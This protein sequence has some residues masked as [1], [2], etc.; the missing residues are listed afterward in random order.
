LSDFIKKISFIDGDEAS[1]KLDATSVDPAS[2]KTATISDVLRRSDDPLTPKVRPNTRADS[3]PP[4]RSLLNG[5]PEPSSSRGLLWAGIILGVLTLIALATW[6][7]SHFAGANGGLDNLSTWQWAGLICA[8]IVPAAAVVALFATLNALKTVRERSDRLAAITDRLTRADSTVANEI[9]SLATVIRREIAAVDARMAETRQTLDGFK[10]AIAEQG[11]DLDKTTK[12]MAERSET[13]GRALTLHRQ[14]FDSLSTTFDAQMGRL[15]EQMSVQR[16]D[17]EGTTAKAE[18][19]LTASK[20]AIEAA[21]TALSDTISQ[22]TNSTKTAQETLDAARDRLAEIIIQVEGTTTELDTVYT[23]HSA[24][25]SALSE[26][27]IDEKNSTEAA[28]L[29]Q[30][31]RLGAID[32]QIEITE[33]RLSQLVDHARSIHE[34][35]STQITAIDNTLDSADARS[36]R[37]TADLSNRVSDAVADAR[38]DIS[39]MEED[40]RALQV[41]L[42]T[43]DDASAELDL[44][45]GP[46]QS[47]SSRVR[48]RPLETDFPSLEPPHPTYNEREK[49]PLDL[50]ELAKDDSQPSTDDISLEA[51]TPLGESRGG[52]RDVLRRPGDPEPSKKR[53]SFGRANEESK[54]ERSGWRWRDML[55]GMDPLDSEA[56]GSKNIIDNN[57]KIIRPPAG[58]PLSPIPPAPQLP[59]GSDVVA[60]LCEVQL[61]PSAVV[62]EGTIIEASQ[63]QTTV[64]KEQMAKLVSHRLD[65]P[66][67]HLRG[68]LAADLEFK[69]RA[70][71]FV[72]SMDGQ[73][74]SIS[75]PDKMRAT[76]GSASGRAFLLCSAALQS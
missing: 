50:V 4:I 22:A 29:A 51:D 32:A 35:L 62:D 48:L 75:D 17:F 23:K 46:S 61:A 1:G 37:F 64:G 14:A 72:R 67:A 44:T 11:K 30:A 33:S 38:R 52:N 63:T 16:T 69:L 3:A 68:V 47:P 58:V 18:A 49:T 15:S 41:R 5:E 28:L 55:G 60:R 76:L 26:K 42:R 73:V 19:D 25:L 45:A 65:G 36:Q 57:P 59:D 20:T 34:T 71:S 13:V 66:V 43:T 39:M 6:T 56:D 10:S 40:L 54:K 8:V 31:E 27:A 53:R 70:E 9:E 24:Q 12:T 7:Y 21:G 2:A 74:S